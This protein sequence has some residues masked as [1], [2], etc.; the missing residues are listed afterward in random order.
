M[1]LT[2]GPNSNPKLLVFVTRTSVKNL[3]LYKHI[4]EFRTLKVFS[5]LSNACKHYD[6]CLIRY[7]ATIKLLHRKNSMRDKLASLFLDG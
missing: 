1:R 4:A 3:F 5:L 6:Y 2:V 7:G